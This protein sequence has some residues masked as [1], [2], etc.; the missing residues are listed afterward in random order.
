MTALFTQIEKL[1]PT[2][3][4]WCSVAKAQTLAAAVIALRPEVSVEIGV[5]GGRSLFP[6]ALAHKEIGKGRV[7]A[8]DPWSRNC[9]RQGQTGDHAKWWGEV[10]DHEA[11]YRDFLKH[12]R[13]LCVAHL[14]SIQRMTSDLCNPPPV[15]DL[16]SLDGNHGPQVLIDVAR[17]CPNVRIGGLLFLDDLNWEGGHVLKAA[18]MLRDLG[19][20]ELTRIDTGAIYQ[21][22]SNSIRP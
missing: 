14:V 16:F 4:G 12:C 9:S 15:I 11:V 18:G 3:H 2:L 5:F 20:M 1:I 7:V 6:I 17:Y 10:A 8:I 22:I 21:K 13:E 19:F